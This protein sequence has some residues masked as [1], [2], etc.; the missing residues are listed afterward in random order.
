[1]HDQFDV[2]LFNTLG[3]NLLVVLLGGWVLLNDGGLGGLSGLGDVLD[4]VSLRGGDEILW[5]GLAENDVGV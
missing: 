4:G 2:L 3:V 5:L 1:M